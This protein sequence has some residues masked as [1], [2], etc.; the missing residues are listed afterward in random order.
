MNENQ[1]S[2]LLES[3]LE[4]VGV[5]AEGQ[6]VLE[7]KMGKRFNEVDRRFDAMDRRLGSLE[8]RTSG[9]EADIKELKNDNKIFKNYLMVI[10]DGF[11]DHENRIQGLEKIGESGR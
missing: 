3:I 11:N 8:K 5:I 2:V 9:I 10:E 7:E 1:F 4:K 6:R